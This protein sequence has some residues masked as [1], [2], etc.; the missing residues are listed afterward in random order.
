LHSDD[1]TDLS[2]HFV[3]IVV[4][5]MDGQLLA[6]A[7]YPSYDPNTMDDNRVAVNQD[8]RRPLFSRAFRERYN[9]GSTIKPVLASAALTERVITPDETVYC[10]GHFYPTRTDIFRCLEVHQSVSLVRAIAESCNVYFYTV[11]QR[12]GIERLVKWYGAYGFGRET[13]MELPESRGNL[14][15]VDSSDPDAARS[16]AMFMGIGQGPIDATPLQMANAYATL[17]RGGVMIAPRI[18]ADTPP[19]ESRP[20]Q[21]S[22]EVLGPIREGMENCTTSGSG[23]SVFRNFVIRVAGKTGT[24]DRFR[25][26]FD[27]NGTPVDDPARPLKNADGSPVLKPDGTPAYRQKT[28]SQTDA[29]FVGYSPI[30]RPRFLVAAVMENGGRGGK[31]AAPIVKEAFSLLLKHHYLSAEE[32]Q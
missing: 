2:D 23:K 18:L 6:L 19:Q 29:W 22:S 17:L 1:K 26:V 7:S 15:N 32:A 12:M 24:A 31:A 25:A 30:N 8:W 27:S 9:P 4:L 14:P 28:E 20:F 16:N 3:G 5:S 13:G 21:L 10:T 11:G